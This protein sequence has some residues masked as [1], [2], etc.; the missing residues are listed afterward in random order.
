MPHHPTRFAPPRRRALAV[1]ALAGLAA[2][3][4]AAPSFAGK[5]PK[6]RVAVS[7]FENEVYFHGDRDFG[8]LGPGLS[9]M[10]VQALMDSG[11]FIVVERE[12][13]ADVLA[14]QNL[15][16]A[17]P[18]A[19]GIEAR[20][21]SAQALIRGTITSIESSDGSEGGLGLGKFRVGAGAARLEISVNIRVIDTVTGQIIASKSVK[22]A[23]KKRK[24]GFRKVGGKSQAEYKGENGVS[25]HDA[26]ESCV[27]DAVEQIVEGMAQIPWQGWVA[28][29]SGKR[30]YVNAGY[31]EN[32]EAGLRLRVFERG[33]PLIDPETN[34][35]LG[36]L[37]EEIGIVE[38]EE[39]HPRFSIARI[40]EGGGFAAGNMV[41]PVTTA[42]GGR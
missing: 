42:P 8:D 7:T 14:E 17:A 29:V 36:S 9:E 32:V 27:A 10:L 35:N 28:R 1:L 3:L 31:Q 19:P 40:L 33:A 18:V 30:V 37:D 12:G 2:T 5:E 39:V 6:K 15:H 25:V 24:F 22:G 4:G 16:E 26:V 23:A 20:L 38:I 13:L 11:K 34:E 41:R 21:T